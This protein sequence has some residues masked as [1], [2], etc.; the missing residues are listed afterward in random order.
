MSKRSGLS[1]LQDLKR[2]FVDVGR[3]RYILHKIDMETWRDKICPICRKGFSKEIG[4]FFM[5]YGVHDECYGTPEFN[6]WA[7]K[8]YEDDDDV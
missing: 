7:D 3:Y 4:Y 8:F 5:S 6:T 1:R 2:G